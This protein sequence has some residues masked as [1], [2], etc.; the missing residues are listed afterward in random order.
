MLERI[1]PRAGRGIRR[2]GPGPRPA[3]SPFAQSTD[4]AD[5]DWKT[6][7]N[8]GVQRVAIGLWARGRQPQHV[9]PSGA[10][11]GR[12][13]GFLVGAGGTQATPDVLGKA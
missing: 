13:V 1:E 10:E 12:E 6:Q 2:H 3:G 5:D 4:V 7:G 11:Q 8:R 9:R